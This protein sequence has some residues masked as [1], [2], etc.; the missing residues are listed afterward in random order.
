[1]AANADEAYIDS[2]WRAIPAHV[3]QALDSAWDNGM[4][5]LASALYARWWQ[6]ESWLRTLIYIELKA[7]FGSS[8]AKKLPKTA[9][10]RQQGEQ[11]FHHMQTPDAQS[12]LAYTDASALFKVTLEH[13]DLFERALL[14]KKVWMGRI[15]ELRAI[16]NRIGHCRR[17]HADDLVRLE[18]TLRN[19]DGGA[20]RAASA[21]NSQHRAADTW[22]DV[23]TDGWCE[24]STKMPFGL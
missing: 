24:S 4:P 3:R 9:T 10:D 20:F 1:V 12:L 7:N 8:W 2:D 21:F 19:L 22:T 5:P 16:R 23:I 15:E 14:S 6:L 13:W 17:P 18:Q 11:E